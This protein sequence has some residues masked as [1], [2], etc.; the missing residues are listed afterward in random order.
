MLLS[1]AGIMSGQ[2]LSSMSLST[3]DEHIG[4]ALESNSISVPSFAEHGA[5]SRIGSLEPDYL[6][7]SDKQILSSLGRQQV[8]ME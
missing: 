5:L 3:L 1:H 4:S 8:S 7:G 6:Q 2:P